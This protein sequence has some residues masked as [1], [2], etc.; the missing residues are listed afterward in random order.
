MSCPLSQNM[1]L[2]T[3]FNF[4]PS[5]LPVW[6]TLYLKEPEDIFIT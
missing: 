5:D 3:D 1:S 2:V 6:N 4:I